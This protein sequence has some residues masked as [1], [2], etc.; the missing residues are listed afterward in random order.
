MAH[1]R[2][3][4]A[5]G[6]QRTEVVDKPKITIGRDP[7]NDIILRHSKVSRRHAVILQE[8]TA[9]SIIDTKSSNGTFV[10]NEKIST[11]H[12]IFDGD[13]IKI[14]DFLLT[15]DE[16]PEDT[17]SV[18]IAQHRN[19]VKEFQGSSKV[20][21]P[22]AKSAALEPAVRS[23]RVTVKESVSAPASPTRLDEK[24]LD[25]LFEIRKEVH[26]RLLE[27]MD[28]RKMD[29]SKIQDLQLRDDTGKTIDEIITELSDDIPPW[30]DRKALSKDVLD[31]ALGLGPLEDYLSDD[32]I[33][34]VMVNNADL[35]YI[36]RAGKIERVN[37]RFS[38]NEAVLAVIERIVGPIGR[39]IDE[40]SPYVDA[41]LK[42]GSRVNAIIPPLALNG[43]TITIRK[44]SRD[45]FT[46]DDLIRFNTC[47]P[48]MAG[49]LRTCVVGKRNIIISGGTGSGK[50]TLLNV[51]SSYIPEEERIITIEDAAELQLPQVHV[52]SLE[53][54]PS[55]IEGKGAITIRDL[56]K[57]SLRMRPDRIVVGECRGAEALDMLQA[58][59]TGHEGSIST[60]HANSPGDTLHRLETMVL[61]AGMEMPILAIRDQIASAINLIVQTARF[62][63]GTRKITYISELSGFDANNR[64][65]MKHLCKYYQTGINAKGKIEGYFGATGEVPSFL[66][67]FKA[68][69][70][71]IDETIFAS[72]MVYGER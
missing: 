6:T 32:T 42:D 54:R 40:S 49:F 58:M 31:E 57:N 72:G 56:V 2:I 45:P 69:G 52:I 71:T 10:N 5:N 62:S 13:R 66:N 48:E 59:N 1:I 7:I 70:I 33:T 55:N 46:I 38:S 43:P 12:R 51:V 41:R 34:E 65:I 37:R 21:I 50:T 24:R 19:S 20:Q 28:L 14:G 17:K 23:S 11:K 30:V 63:D 26:R 16:A 47:A 44:F 29:F 4:D 35:I 36:E 25:V 60:V 8:E 64:I 9:F 18:G 53:S 68:R 3:V 22:A 61:M 27:Y 39:R 15:I 67:D